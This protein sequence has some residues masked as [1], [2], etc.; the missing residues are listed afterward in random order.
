[1]TH[2]QAARGVYIG[3]TLALAAFVWMDPFT[4]W[5]SA[6]DYRIPG[7]T[8]QTVATALEIAI[9]AWIVAQLWRRQFTKSVR[10]LL[11]ETLWALLYN[12]VLIQ[13]YGLQRFVGGVGAMELATRFLLLLVLRVVLVLA[14]V[15]VSDSTENC[16]GRSE[17]VNS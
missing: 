1:M 7:P 6:G 10:L 17:G 8:W 9:L 16:Q 14:L 13:V 4:F 15:H 12:V 3:A 5:A 11:L 2:S